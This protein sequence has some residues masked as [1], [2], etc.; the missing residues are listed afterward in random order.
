MPVLEMALSGR[1]PGSDDR[2]LNVVV[3]SV[4]LDPLRRPP[5]VLVPAWRDFGQLEAAAAADGKTRV[6]IVQASWHDDTEIVAGVEAHFV[7]DRAPLLPLPGGRN[8]RR[9]PRRLYA[10][11]RQLA[12]DVV[13][14]QGLRFP[15]ELRG[16]QRA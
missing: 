15:R 8:V 1:M 3:V 11:V 10:R 2:D 4:H 14:F 7:R 12:P 6:T 16:L 9:L 5:A 13:H